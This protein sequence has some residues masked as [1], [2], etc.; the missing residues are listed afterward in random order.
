[1]GQGYFK[2][3]QNSNGLVRSLQ[4]NNGVSKPNISQNGYLDDNAVFVVPF[5]PVNDLQTVYGL[6]D[7]SNENFRTSV[8]GY[9][10]GIGNQAIG[11]L[12][13]L[14]QTN[15]SRQPLEDSSINGLVGLRFD[16]GDDQMSIS[17]AIKTLLNSTGAEIFMI[18]KADADPPPSWGVS[19]LMEFGSAGSTADH[20][21]EL[22][23]SILTSFGRS[24]RVNAGNPEASL[25]QAN[26]INIRSYQNDWQYHL[27]DE[28]LFSTE[29]NTVAFGDYYTFGKSGG[30]GINFKGVIGEILLGVFSNEERVMIKNYMKDKWATP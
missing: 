8:D 21:P 16:G 4:S 13:P 5:N 30:S 20:F 7:P 23:G 22:G 24:N 2:L 11:E 1:M 14:V 6:W 17:S 25:T 28:F 10:S 27:N 3:N 18:V 12:Y 9:V 26:L 15:Q 29:T 19:G